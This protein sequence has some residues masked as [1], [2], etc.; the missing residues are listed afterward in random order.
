PVLFEPSAALGLLSELVSAASGEALYRSGSFLK[1]G[2]D[3]S[4]FPAHVELAEDPFVER[5]MASRCFDSDGIPGWRRKVVEEGRLR[6]FFLG[7]YSARR[8]N[9]PPTGNGHGPHNLVLSST[10]TRPGDDFAAMVGKLH[11]GLLVTEM[12]GGGVNRL[13]GDFSRGAK[14]FWVENGEIRFPVGGI[15]IAS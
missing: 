6:G 15:T 4:L 2:I 14:G 12:V 5:G 3:S 1:D 13:T 10:R 9:L 8:L 11:R 7:L